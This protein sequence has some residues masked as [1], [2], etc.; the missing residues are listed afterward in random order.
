MR[1]SRLLLSLLI[2]TALTVSL[3]AS[4]TIVTLGNG[5]EVMLVEN[6]SNPVIAS[7]VVVRT[8]LRNES[9]E[10][11]GATHFL[12][13]LLFNGTETR[14]QKQ[15][16]DEMDFLGGYNNANTAHD[17]TTFMILLEKSNF[18]RGLEIQ[19]DM[20]FHSTL[21]PD[22]FEKEK[23]IVIEEI[24]K[25]EDSESWRAE[26]FFDQVIHRGTPYQWPILGSRNSIR[27]LT[28]EQV[29]DYYKTYYVPNN[30][31]ALIM[32]DFHTPDM[33]AMVERVFG[34]E[35][36]GS[37]PPHPP[38]TLPVLERAQADGAAAHFLNPGAASSHRVRLVHPAPTRSA[39]DYF[40]FQAAARLLGDRLEQDLKAVPEWGVTEVSTYPFT[41]RDFGTLVVDLTIDAKADYRPAL[42]AIHH[43]FLGFLES[44]PPAD[45]VQAAVTAIRSEEIFNA[46]RP[47]YYG[48]L[49][50]EDLAQ[51]GPYFLTDYS[52]R[53]AGVTPQ[54]VSQAAQKYLGPTYPV[55]AVYQATSPE[56]TAAARTSGERKM[57][58]K[59]L[60]N[61]LLAV[62]EQN[63]DSRVFA[64]HFLFK[65]RSAAET[66]LGARAGTVDYLHHLFEL[67]PQGMTQEAY[68]AAMQSL[69]AQAKYCDMAFIPYDDYY[70]TPEYSYVRLEA[71]D[72]NYVPA[73]ELV[74][75]TIRTPDLSD[76]AVATVR[77]QMMGLAKRNQASVQES[78]KALFRRL[79][80]GESPLAAD[81]VGSMEDAVFHTVP[82]LQDFHRAYFSPGNLIL[83]VVTSN[84]A[85]SVL[86]RIESLFGDWTAGNPPPVASPYPQ[87]AAA[88]ARQE[89]AGGKEQSYLGMGYSF[90]LA[91]P[92][93]QAPLSIL[94]AI[95][96]ERM[97]FQLREKEG[98]AYTLGSSVN[99]YPG[100]GVWAAAMGTGPQNLVR[101]EEGIREQVKKAAKE[102]FRETDVAKARNAYLGRQLLRG[103]SRIN[104]AYQMGLGEFRGEG[105][106]SYRERLEE[107]RRVTVEDVN[108]V[109]RQYLNPEGMSL[110]VV[111]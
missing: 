52:D 22:K 103:L 31:T 95:L 61:G 53:L 92:A 28:R 18:E 104:Q 9:V 56:E 4:P 46:E 27:R 44:E 91:N 86:A 68:Q 76:P 75:R 42:E 30:M 37:L 106:D 64:A 7:V 17:R 70:T 38:L 14:S 108:R 84:P 87:P 71:L 51:A 78:G 85:D 25:D 67:G 79:L 35:A 66:A 74:G 33:V 41:D 72:D 10:L 99:F 39:P 15:L 1:H 32:G 81:V 94:N 96:S 102:K 36:P 23:G 24:G 20:L 16:Y 3:H 93:D 21:P 111:R 88:A 83:T 73:L 45:R 11:N 57:A 101:A 63:P 77:G 105:F 109:A 62:V 26:R 98:L 43:S 12:E 6:R 60:D 107:I 100:W 54:E 65:N 90:A 97:Q 5:M 47:H 2:L 48:M 34:K 58:R 69:G 13:H 59:T 8:G 19:A 55:V 80:Y 49:K 50:A 29:Y 89:E 110:V 40:A 82:E